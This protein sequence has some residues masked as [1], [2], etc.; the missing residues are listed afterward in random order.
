M[1]I[2]LKVSLNLFLICTLSAKCLL[3][4]HPV[5][6]LSTSP[7]L[8]VLCPLCYSRSWS[9]RQPFLSPSGSKYYGREN[10]RDRHHLIFAL[11]RRRPP[12][13]PSFSCSLS[14]LGYFEPLQLT[15]V[16]LGPTYYSLPSSFSLSAMKIRTSSS[17][18]SL[19]LP[20]KLQGVG[21]QQ[22]AFE[23]RES[24]RKGIV[25][26]NRLVTVTCERR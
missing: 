9:F 2:G 17:F 12:F 7:M 23:L 19:S 1:P 18:L 24:K 3:N 22:L 10:P 21:A 15:F 11:R 8:S 14:R 4:C 13:P 20:T 25:S 16:S 26:R 6:R 5:L